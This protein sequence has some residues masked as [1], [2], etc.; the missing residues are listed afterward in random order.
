MSD[1]RLYSRDPHVPYVSSNRGAVVERRRS[2]SPDRDRDRRER[3]DYDDR[4][5][6]DDRSRGDAYRRSPPRRG[7]GPMRRGDRSRSRSRERTPPPRRIPGP[8]ERPAPEP[9]DD[10]H[11]EFLRVAAT[12]LPQKVAGAIAQRVRRG[13][14]TAVEA[15]GPGAAHQALKGCAIARQYLAEDSLDLS[16]QVEWIRGGRNFRDDEQEIRF[17]IFDYKP[18]SYRMKSD[19]PMKVAAHTKPEKTAGAIAMDLRNRVSCS[20]SALGAD[21]V[22]Q[23]LKAI[24]LAR[25]FVEGD[26]LDLEF[27][28]FYADDESNVLCCHIERV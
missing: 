2:R 16:L 14:R 7:G 21:S 15:L 18:R 3:R 5:R 20:V 27:Q 9:L 25:N 17:E 26:K 28:P 4:D 12:T 19:H 1:R 22:F 8:Y 23:A 24:I 6:R 10:S 13:D 11:P